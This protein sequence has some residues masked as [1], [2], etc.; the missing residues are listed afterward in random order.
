MKK[1]KR[2][3]LAARLE[4]DKKKRKPRTSK[5][6]YSPRGQEP[7]TVRHADGTVEVKKP[8]A[9]GR[10]RTKYSQYLSSPE[11]RAKRKLV[12]ERD[13]Y[14]CQ[15]CAATRR[16]QVHH[17]T[18]ERIFKERLDD[19]LTLCQPCHRRLHDRK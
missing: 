6:E 9:F 10:Q 7:V 2:A 11:W 14:K 16:L 1:A 8:S 13:N 4:A 19:L 18:Y 15:R 17:L 12:L 3:R 5:A